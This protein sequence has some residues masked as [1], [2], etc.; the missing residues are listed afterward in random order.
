[1][2]RKTIAVLGLGLFGTSLARTLTK[3]NIDVIGMDKNMDHV[4][5]IIDEVA[6]CLQGDFTKIDQLKDA[7]VGDCDIAVV[8]T[9]QRLEDTI[10]AILHLQKLGI[11]KIIVK[12]KNADYRDVL[13]KVGA[14]RVILPEVEMGVRIARELSNPT[15]HELI[16]LDNRNNISIFPVKDKWIGKTIN[17][18]N[19][20]EKYGTNIIAIRK[21]NT[22]QFHVEFTGDYIIQEND[23]FLG[24]STGDTLRQQFRN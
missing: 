23:E 9:S 10:L 11:E 14:D 8:A 4:E 18:M 1:M 21:E 5:E 12:S 13:L 24:I 15:V 6:Q 20:R 16:G 19:F 3:E 22:E 17:Q 7:G 2:R